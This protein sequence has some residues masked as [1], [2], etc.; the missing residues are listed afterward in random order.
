M[1]HIVLSDDGYNV[2]P[3]AQHRLLVVCYFPESP[4]DQEQGLFIAAREQAEFDRVGPSAYKPSQIVQAASQM[5]LKRTA[6]YYSAGFVALSFIWLKLNGMT[7]SLNRAAIM[8]ACVANE[9]RGVRWWN[10]LDP[11]FREREAAVTS[12]P[13]TVERIFR[14]YRSVAHILAASV[15]AGS[16]LD[17]THL[18]DRPPEV[19]A[20]MIVTCATFQA[21]LEKATDV[22]DWNLWDV[23]KHYPL[24]LDGW[25]ALL[26]DNNLEAWIR[27]GFEAAIEQGLMRDPRGG[28]TES[29]RGS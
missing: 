7:P 3:T 14:E 6:R 9:V 10:T 19:I 29:P 15:S 27:R 28:T 22:S 24:S 4:R 21:A 16:Y 26:P 17:P 1:R 23:K 12:D 18:W 8:A 25:P 13:A 20:S 5:I 2:A 11:E